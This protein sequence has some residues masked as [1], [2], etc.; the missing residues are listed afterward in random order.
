MSAI[1]PVVLANEGLAKSMALNIEYY[2]SRM[3]I[4]KRRVNF[5]HGLFTVPVVGEILDVAEYNPIAPAILAQ[6]PIVR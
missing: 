4:T 3:Y 6:L 5:S 1:N 2:R